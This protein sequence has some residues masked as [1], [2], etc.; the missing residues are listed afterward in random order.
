MDFTNNAEGIPDTLEE[1]EGDSVAATSRPELCTK[2]YA[3]T[4]SAGVF[5]HKDAS[6]FVSLAASGTDAQVQ[7]RSTHC[8]C[9]SR[10]SSRQ[11]KIGRSS[12]TAWRGCEEL[13][14][15][16]VLLHVPC[17]DQ[18]FVTFR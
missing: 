1:P 2:L 13:P 17:R 10:R 7:L 3:E 5:T 9:S 15:P 6:D 11:V 8:A 4:L 12:S 16:V 18:E 14:F